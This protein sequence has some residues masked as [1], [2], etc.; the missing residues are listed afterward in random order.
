M[1]NREDS[2]DKIET[3]LKQGA[4]FQAHNLATK[5]FS[6][7]SSVRLIQLLASTES[8]LGNPDQAIELLTPLYQSNPDDPETSGL[9][10][11]AY[12]DLYRSTG[13]VELLRKSRDIYLTNFRNSGSYYTGINAATLSALLHDASLTTK[14]ASRVIELAEGSEDFWALATMGEAS[15]LL[16]HGWCAG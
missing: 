1:D 6:E 8:K 10:G 15:L 13:N 4:L 16:S 12:K 11:R 2:I 5:S 9:L 7:N 3:F 14:T